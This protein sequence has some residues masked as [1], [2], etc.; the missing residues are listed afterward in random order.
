V[1]LTRAFA[2]T[3]AFPAVHWTTGEQLAP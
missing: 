3:P 2:T 1:G